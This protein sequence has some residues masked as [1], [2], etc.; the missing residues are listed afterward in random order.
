MSGRPSDTP[1]QLAVVVGLD[2]VRFAAAEADHRALQLRISEYVREASSHALWPSDQA[3]VRAKLDAGQVAAAIELYFARVGDR[4]DNEYLHTCTV[5][6]GERAP[7][8]HKGL[9][10]G[11]TIGVPVADLDAGI[12]WYRRLLGVGEE[13]MPTPEVWER[14]LLPSVWLQ[15]FEQPKG[16]SGESVLRLEVE[17]IDVPRR[18]LAR[19]NEDVGRVRTVP[20][21]VRY[22]EFRDPFG[23]LMSYYEL[24]D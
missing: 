19:M 14:E 5:N 23:N 13:L 16:S 7:S 17:D 21:A 10:R 22:F 2:G 24:L 20:T 12:E 15:L 1:I 11:A 18:N 4:W 9:V 6:P 3:E 8:R